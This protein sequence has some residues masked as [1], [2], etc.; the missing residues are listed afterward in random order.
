[1]ILSPLGHPLVLF[2]VLIIFFFTALIGVFFVVI[3]ILTC[4][5]NENK[6]YKKPSFIIGCILIGYVSI[7]CVHYALYD[8]IFAGKFIT[9]DKQKW[10]ILKG[11]NTWTSNSFNCSDGTWR[12]DS[13]EDGDWLN[14]NHECTSE[15]KNYYYFLIDL[16]ENTL[17]SSQG[18][19][20]RDK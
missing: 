9:S 16:D 10:I 17:K 6:V 3:G 13:D 4:R 2:F 11:N 18:N 15:S 19:F 7:N 12:Y 8:Y 1:M 5:K 20:Y 14:L